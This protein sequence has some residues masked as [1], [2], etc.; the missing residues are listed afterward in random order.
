MDRSPTC[1]GLE[2]PGL[3]FMPRDACHLDACLMQGTGQD[4]SELSRGSVPNSL[5]F[6]KALYDLFAAWCQDGPYAGR[7]LCGLHVDLLNTKGR[8]HVTFVQVLAKTAV[9][10][11]TPEVSLLWLN[12]VLLLDDTEALLHGRMHAD[13]LF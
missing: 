3:P 11:G 2:V 1:T 6:R 13:T 9:A 7:Y 5:T 8:S 4:P 10:F 12:T